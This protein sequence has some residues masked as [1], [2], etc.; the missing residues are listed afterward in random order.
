MTQTA[1][2]VRCN[3]S[4]KI[5]R[6]KREGRETIIV[7]SYAA[8]ADTVLNGT[9]YPKD[10][11][12]ATYAGLSRTPAPF[13][14]PVINGKYVPA[15]DPEAMA[16]TSIFAWNENARWDGDRIALD[17]V[18]DEARANQLGIRLFKVACPWPFDV[19]HMRPILY[20]YM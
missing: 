16:R 19:E 8:K 2:H 15:K 7:P 1:I 6:E 17:V 20:V 9:F 18:I 3:V 13:G 4:G 5:K 11:L 14:H 12:E 10:E